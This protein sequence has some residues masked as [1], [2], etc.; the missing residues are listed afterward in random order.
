MYRKREVLHAV[1]GWVVAPG[2]D[3]NLTVTQRAAL[4]VLTDHTAQQFPLGTKL[5]DLIGNRTFRYCQLGAV[6]GV[7]GALYQSAVPVAHHVNI[8][9]AAAVPIGDTSLTV[10]AGA[11]ASVLNAYA[12]GYMVILG[13][14]GAGYTYR[15][16]S[17]SVV[18]AG[19]GAC[20]VALYD[21][22]KVALATA[23]SKIAIV[24]NPCKGL[25]IHP[26]V[27]TARVAGLLPFPVAASRFGWC[28]T[29]G[30]AGVLGNGT[31]VI[32][33]NCVPGATTDGTVDVQPLNSVDAGGQEYVMGVV[34]D[35]QAT[36][37][38][39]TVFLKLE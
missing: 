25:V 11:T 34:M 30:P 5:E 14:T 38:Y 22:I 23:D 24:A 17:S 12:G 2:R 8:P 39:S 9:P 15:V 31:L 16:K 13:G 21:P 36:T 10:T 28:Q 35:V 7:A 32:G 33:L 18:A 26:S 6:A 3:D 19:G 37:K 1:E 29:R 4:D 20:V 27:P